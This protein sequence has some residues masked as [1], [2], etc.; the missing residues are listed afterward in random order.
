MPAGIVHD[1]LSSAIETTL[2]APSG[3]VRSY[4]DSEGRHG[5]AG[6]F[7]SVFDG[8]IGLV[9]SANSVRAENGGLDQVHLQLRQG[10][11]EFLSV[12]RP[13][14][15][16]PEWDEFRRRSREV[17]DRGI[18]AVR[19]LRGAE[20]LTQTSDGSLRLRLDLREALKRA[21]LHEQREV[22]AS[23]RFGPNELDARVWLAQERIHRVLVTIPGGE[24]LFRRW[25]AM[26]QLTEIL[27]VGGSYFPD[28][29]QTW[30]LDS[31]RPYVERLAASWPA[32]DSPY[33]VDPPPQRFLTL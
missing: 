28:L 6:Y 30:T 12:Y 7:R 27:D 19:W 8:R 2:A 31:V 33:H 18:D 17:L 32:D 29:P 10:R 11:Q 25:S 9:V 4:A 20:V 14:E 1:E 26:T 23:I 21:L 3:V 16:A 24:K 13:E 5:F 15:A 22:K